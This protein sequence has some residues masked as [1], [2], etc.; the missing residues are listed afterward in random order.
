MVR[1]MTENHRVVHVRC[2]RVEKQGGGG[3]VRAY[4]PLLGRDEDPFILVDEK[5]VVPDGDSLWLKMDILGKNDGAIMVQPID[6]P[7]DDLMMVAEMNVME[8]W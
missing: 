7:V 2:S 1:N 8:S 6:S 5:H 3:M 4:V